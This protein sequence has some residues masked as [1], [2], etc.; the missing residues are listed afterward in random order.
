[1]H[2]ELAA[3]LEGCRKFQAV[4][5]VLDSG[6]ARE[7]QQA[8]GRLEKAR[9]A[10]SPLLA[11]SATE[12]A[13]VVLSLPETRS[14]SLNDYH[15]HRRPGEV[16][17]ARILAGEGVQSFYERFQAHFDA[18]L[19]QYR[20]EE[21][22]THGW[23]Q[24]PRTLEYLDA[25]DKIDVKMSDRYLRDLIRQTRAHVFSTQAADEM[26]ILHLAHYLMGVSAEDL[27]GQNNAPPE[28]GATETQRAWFFKLFALRGM[29]NNLERMCFFV[30]LQKSSDSLADE[31]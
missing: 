11:Q 4:I 31:W 1:M 22:Q 14:L 30:Y 19:G 12:I 3:V 29:T 20:E 5:S 28:D 26:D 23:K 25:L 10:E 13:E 2:A 16:M 7:I 27:V 21:R 17:L 8:M 9:I 6:T 18:A 24:D 15:V